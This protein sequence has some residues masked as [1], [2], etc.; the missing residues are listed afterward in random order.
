MENNID[1]DKIGT[2]DVITP[3]EQI[4]LLSNLTD[5]LLLE[6]IYEQ[7]ATPILD[8]YEPTNF[9]DV[10]ESRYKFLSARFHDTPDFLTALS[11]T[12]RFFYVNISGRICGKF[13]FELDLSDERLYMVTKVLYEFF[14]LNYKENIK[15]F[16]IE[17]VTENKKTLV[18]TF[19]D[20][21]KTLDLVSAKKIFKNK[22]DAILVSNI[23]RVI[24]LIIKQDLPVRGIL[25]PIVKADSSEFTNYVVDEL[26]IQGDSV[27]VDGK[28][29]RTFFDVLIRKG[30]GYTKIVN[31]LQMKLFS[32]FPKKI[33]DEE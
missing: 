14:V 29:S 19:D 31:D 23:Y 21:S 6:N 7:I 16:I 15:T 22:G 32:M 1:L 27:H 33:G 11:D 9:I 18:S 30:D 13:G 25:E 3:N 17:Y 28:F 5:D 12:R 20:G 2:E 8:L 4:V 26:F 24:D 10:F